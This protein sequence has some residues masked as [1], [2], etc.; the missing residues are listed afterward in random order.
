MG[1]CNEA[2]KTARHALGGLYLQSTQRAQMSPARNP[3]GPLR[4]KQTLQICSNESTS[5]YKYPVQ[6]L[7]HPRTLT[8]HVALTLALDATVERT[9]SAVQCPQTAPLAAGPLQKCTSSRCWVSAVDLSESL[10]FLLLL[11]LASLAFL[12]SPSSSLSFCVGPAS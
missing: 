2:L 4:I 1:F 9:A 3:S 5:E 6:C 10:L 11:F 12:F 8:L 7:V